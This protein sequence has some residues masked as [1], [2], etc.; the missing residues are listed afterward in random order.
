VKI[1]REML[2]RD[3]QKCSLSGAIGPRDA[4]AGAYFLEFNE[5]LQ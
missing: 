2:N 4:V 5:K 3:P 1:G